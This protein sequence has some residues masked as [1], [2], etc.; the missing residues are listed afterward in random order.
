[1]TAGDPVQ[2]R[3]RSFL[4]HLNI[5]ALLLVI[6]AAAALLL[7][8]WDD[9]ALIGLPKITPGERAP[10]TVKSPRDFAIADPTTT[11]RLREDAVSKVL[12]VYDH[13]TALGFEAKN[14][15]ERA[16]AE[17]ADFRL[18]PEE[19]QEGAPTKKPE[20]R[21]FR[22]EE[23]R[24]SADNFMRAL[25]LYLEDHELES[26]FRAGFDDQIRD[27]A[28]MV[29]RTV[30]EQRIAEDKDLL[31]L[32][33]PNGA[34]IRAIAP[35]GDVEHE[36]RLID[37]RSIAGLDQARALVDETVAKKLEHLSPAARRAVS[38]VV[39]RLLRPNISPNAGETHA[40]WARARE[41]VRQVVI[42]IKR[43]ETVIS[44]GE[45]VTD[46]HL[47][48]LE[49]IATELEAESR[50]QIPLGN[51]LIVVLL[52]IVLYLFH[53]QGRRR[54]FADHRDLAFGATVFVLN[55]L[56]HWLSFE[57]ASW[58]AELFPSVGVTT[59]QLL[60]PVSFGALLLRFMIGREEAVAFVSVSSLSVGL[61]M[62]HSLAYAAYALA[63]GVAAASVVDL[64]RPRWQM[65]LGGIAAGTAQ[66]CTMVAIALFESRLNSDSIIAETAA[67]MLSGIASTALVALVVPAVDVLFGYLSPLKL[68]DLANLNHPLLRDLLVQA[69]GTYHHSIVVGALAEAGARAV[70]ADPLL[71]RV[72]G[73][74]HDIG[75]LK[76]PR[77]YPE[78][79][80]RRGR[81]DDS[82][83]RGLSLVTSEQP[84]VDEAAEIKLHV[85]DGLEIGAQHRLGP[86]I[87]E[88]IAQHHGTGSVR[89]LER[90]VTESMASLPPMPQGAFEYPGPKPL[91]AEAALV[92]LADCAEAATEALLA[93]PPIDA[94][95][96]AATVERVVNEAISAG[97]LE[98]CPLTLRDLNA[99]SREFVVVLMDILTRRSTRPAA[100]VTS[101]I[102]VPAPLLRAVSAE[103][104]EPI[105]R[106][107]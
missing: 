33:A 41:A 85:P 94:S 38:L 32:Q 67:A 13:F 72:G 12:P 5:A 51:A 68:E 70:D 18:P 37:L 49:G 64:D 63:G 11:E 61:M 87:L 31:R 103:E 106:S 23:D 92:M 65:V 1:M 46:R 2:E 104:S 6:A 57:G 73:Y 54:F 101:E 8:P 77:L 79:A 93:A 62:D 98:H 36:E 25:Q 17:M 24:S 80:G 22:P 99:V 55:L 9:D 15:L 88:I 21:A 75:K 34:T 74:Y 10:R 71:A 47:L 30:Y 78:N 48:I 69:P 28:I 60:A 42:P 96:L 16:Y 40:R 95:M 90:R 53:G 56:L 82:P 105:D 27:A 50:F 29:V 91:S 19:P 43:G 44:A 81:G 89:R 84:V 86:P 76:N 107:S 3:P 100:P 97:Q 66:A 39:K 20:P 4:R 102:P 26:L 7:Q 52:M 58:L 14:R 45:A 35:S 83:R 59:F